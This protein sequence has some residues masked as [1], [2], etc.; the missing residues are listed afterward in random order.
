M[1]LG[2]GYG[3]KTFPKFSTT[4][5]TGTAADASKIICENFNSLVMGLRSQLKGFAVTPGNETLIAQAWGEI[6]SAQGALV[7]AYDAAATVSN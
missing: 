4:A 6:V 2:T 1:E 3:I 7:H 5:P